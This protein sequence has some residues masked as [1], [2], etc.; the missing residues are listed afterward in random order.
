MFILSHIAAT[1]Q[2]VVV[3]PTLEPNIIQI[4]CV[5]HINSADKN[6]SVRIVT[7]ELDCIIDDAKNQNIKLL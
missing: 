6:Q 7:T 4:A 1:N 5:S 3:V 2:A